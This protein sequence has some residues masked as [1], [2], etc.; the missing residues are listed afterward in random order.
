[1]KQVLI[2]EDNPDLRMIFTHA[3]DGGDFEVRAVVDGQEV[4]T[5]LNAQVP[6]ILVLDINMPNMTGLEVLR[7]IHSQP[8][9]Q[10]L[11]VIVV[12]GNPQAKLDAEAEYADLFLLKPVGIFELRMLV[13]RLT[14]TERA[15]VFATAAS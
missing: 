12:T 13:E 1:M 9:M 8:Q 14:R 5:A 6:D 7:Y 15:P 11:K 3:F 2:A 4:V 10:N